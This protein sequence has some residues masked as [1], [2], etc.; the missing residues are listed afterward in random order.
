MNLIE[1]MSDIT[2]MPGID[3]M[4]LLCLDDD[5]FE[6]PRERSRKT[7]REKRQARRQYGLIRAKDRKGPTEQPEGILTID[8]EGMRG[9]QEGDDTLSTVRELTGENS[10]PFC[11][12]SGLL[13][14]KWVP[15][16]GQESVMQLVLPK[17]CRS[18]ALELP[19]SIP[20]AGHLGRKKTLARLAQ[21]FYWPAMH[22]DVAHWCRSC[23]N[24]QKN[25]HRK[26]ARAPMVP[27]PVVEEPF[28][29]MAMDISAVCPQGCKV[30]YDG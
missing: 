6:I 16:G 25:G 28:S 9:M 8:C 3:D 18:K 24:C 22:Q 10:G 21:R 2:V 15:S 29:R 12:K 4:P 17:S 19:H 20:L 27:L 14:R 1:A 13:Y 26:P 30:Y 23:Q 11:L 7:R 5:L